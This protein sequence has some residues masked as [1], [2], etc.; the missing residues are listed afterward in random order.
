MAPVP[1]TDQFELVETFPNAEEDFLDMAKFII[2]GWKDEPVWQTL[3]K[4]TTR[5]VQQAWILKYTFQ[6]KLTMPGNKFFAIR[7]RSTG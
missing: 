1:D 2:D 7:E 5:A 3:V 6:P 4:G